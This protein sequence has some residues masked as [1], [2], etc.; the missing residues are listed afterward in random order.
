MSAT[1][2]GE[3]AAVSA[4]TLTKSGMI[5]NVFP[6]S[7]AEPE[8]NTV[9][10]ALWYVEAVRAYYAATGDAALVRALFPVLEVI[11]AWHRDGTRYGITMDQADGLLR[12]GEP[13]VQLTWM[14]AKVG[15][16]VVTPRMGKPVEIVALWYNALDA[17]A[18]LAR[19][20][21]RVPLEWEQMRERAG[22]GFERFWNADAGHCY[23]VIDGPDGDDPSFRP[24][25]IFAVS[26]PASPLPKERQRQ[27]VD[28]CA[29]HLLASFGLRSLAPGDPRY[30]GQYGGGPAERDS[31][32]HQGTVWGW[33]LGP[34]ARA[35][36]RVY[37]DR[38][39]ARGFLEPMA[40]HLGDYGLG[41]IA[42]IFDGDP[43][44]APRG[45]FAQAW[46]VA[47]TLRA[48]CEI[49]SAPSR[50]PPRARPRN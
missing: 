25:Q 8:Y 29:R 3:A 28:A 37:G 16:W 50:K 47:E 27:V 45:C 34:F 40:Y 4:D 39:A 46:S 2:W 6:D 48:W 1:R 15:D 31:V 33:L 17:M 11:I 30:R 23:D 22:R 41:S 12:A 13:G 21:D 14:D 24:N 44:F 49:D 35:H 36:L 7:G 43:P 38:D 5:P 18:V 32:Y 10:A 42:E 20:V 26:L 9:D 19:L